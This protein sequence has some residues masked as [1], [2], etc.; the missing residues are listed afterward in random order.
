MRRILLSLALGLVVL[1]ALLV[2][3]GLVHRPDPAPLPLPRAT[4]VVDGTRISYHQRGAGPDVVLL[5]GGMGSAED[6]EPVLDDLARDFRVT[7]I[8]RPGFGLSEARG[9][10]PTYPGNARVVAAVVGELDLVRPVVVGHSHGGG[11]ALELAQDHPE[12]PGGLVLIAAAAY[13]D[14]GP[15]VLDQLTAIPLLG[16]GL[17][18]WL[19]PWLGPP[20]V[21]RILADL[22]G[23]DGAHMPPT[24]VS[25][26]QQ[27]FTNPRSLAVHARQA[28]TDLEGLQAIAADLGEVQTPAVVIGCALDSAEGTSV[29]S[30]RLARDLP[31]ARLDWLPGCGHYVQYARPDH[32][33]GAVRTIAA[34][35]AAP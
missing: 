5:H 23:P 1:V 19:G 25:D 7:A 30:R 2:V 18:G 13:P 35:P 10:D 29:D 17:L 8:D 12:L 28:V 22:I 16:E 3:T 6:F 21:A 11:V 33:V 24:F 31:N 32:V 15:T 14:H 27:R 26:R 20:T 34:N 9:D 4:L